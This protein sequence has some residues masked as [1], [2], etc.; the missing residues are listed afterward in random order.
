MHLNEIRSTSLNDLHCV[1]WKFCPRGLWVLLYAQCFWCVKPCWNS[2]VCLLAALFLLDTSE[3]KKEKW[4]HHFAFIFLPWIFHYLPRTAA[5]ES[6]SYL[7]A[8]LKWVAKPSKKN[9]LSVTRYLCSLLPWNSAEPRYLLVFAS[10][11]SCP[12]SD[13]KEDS[14]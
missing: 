7:S 10:C 14:P 9:V 8:C 11:S 1:V 2:V 6:Y 3:G 5:L 4:S 13:G 12:H